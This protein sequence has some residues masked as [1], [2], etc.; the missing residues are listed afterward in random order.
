MH[1]CPF[2]KRKP[3]PMLNI[4]FNQIRL[5]EAV[6]RHQSV[7]QAAKELNISQPAVSSQLKKL[8]QSMG[9][10]LIEVIGRKVYLTATGEAA[11]HQFKTLLNDFEALNTQ[12]RTSQARIEGELSLAG[13]PTCKYFLPFILAEFLKLHPKVIPKLALLTKPQL[14]ESLVKQCHEL[15]ITG[16]KLNAPHT[17]FVPF[18]QQELAIVAAR[19][20]RLAGS[21]QLSLKSLIKHPLILPNQESSIRQAFDQVI[22]N[23]ALSVTPYLEVAGHAL[24][25]QSIMA[26]LGIGLVSADAFRLEAH[27]GHLVRLSVEGFPIVQPWYYAHHTNTTLSPAALAFIEF[28]QRHPIETYLKNIYSPHA[29]D[30]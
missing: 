25:K 1:P 16:K 22:S 29:K 26:G 7:T 11:Y 27:T 19:N 18:M 12:V 15:V 13:V 21:G 3:A 20:H 5:F 30:E 8:A 4:T 28:I 2:F 24:L 17:L 23:A 14:M 10:P 9:D 6:A